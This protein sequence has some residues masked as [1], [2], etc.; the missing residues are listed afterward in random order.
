M[1]QLLKIQQQELVDEMKLRSVS[2][3]LNNFKPY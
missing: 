3:N 1:D 2:L